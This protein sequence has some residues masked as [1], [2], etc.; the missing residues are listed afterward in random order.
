MD[1]R[2]F[3]EILDSYLNGELTVETNHTLQRHAEQC[4]ACRQEMSARRNLRA[5]LREAVTKTTMSA[6]CREQLRERLRT[7]SAPR[8]PFVA[9]FISRRVPLAAAASIIFALLLGGAYGFF[10]LR[11]EPVSAAELSPALIDEAI[12]DHNVCSPYFLNSKGRFRLSEAAA[13]HDPAYADLERVAETSAQGLQLRGTHV[14]TVAGRRFAHLIYLRDTQLI[15]LLVTDRDERA[16]KRGVVPLDDGLRAGLQRALNDDCAF[17]AYQTA[18]HVVIVVS[19]LSEKENQELAKQLA[20]PVS[21]HLRRLEKATSVL[22]I[23]HLDWPELAK[24]NR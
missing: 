8:L 23:H 20:G 1:C 3:K 24:T 11:Q 4:A 15:S 22:H 21:E 13:Q 18:R 5:L 17:G 7:E 9:R 2:N 19:R 16:M 10:Y 14:C 12:K 6:E